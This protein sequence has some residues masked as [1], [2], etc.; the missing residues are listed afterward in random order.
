M[1]KASLQIA[2]EKL[3]IAGEQ[4][5]LSVEQMDLPFERWFE[6]GNPLGFDRVASRI[7]GIA[8]SRGR[9]CVQLDHVVMTRDRLWR[10]IRNAIVIE[11]PFWL[12]LF[13]KFS[14]R[15]R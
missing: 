3:A 12:I 11:L 15:A 6:R 10:G 8:C 13:W 2:I 9:I 14:S 5:G 7:H 1:R 4:A